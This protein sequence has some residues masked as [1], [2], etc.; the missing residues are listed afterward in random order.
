MEKAAPPSNRRSLL[1]RRAP[2]EAVTARDVQ[3]PLQGR[4]RRAGPCPLIAVAFEGISAGQVREGG[5]H[6]GAVLHRGLRNEVGDFP[7]GRGAFGVQP[8][9]R[10]ALDFASAAGLLGKLQAFLLE[11]IS[12]LGRY[13]FSIL[14]NCTLVIAG[15][16]HDRLGLVASLNIVSASKR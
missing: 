11:L 13:M 10:D 5:P 14:L 3:S 1:S 16:P 15:V 4:R 8:P 7:I 2:P 12:A 6:V 9:D